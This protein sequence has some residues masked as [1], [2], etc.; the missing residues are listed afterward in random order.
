MDTHWFWNGQKSI[1]WFGV[2]DLRIEK[3]REKN[4][5]FFSSIKL[6][7]RI[8]IHSHAHWLHSYIHLRHNVDTDRIT[9]F[10][11][12]CRSY[13]FISMHIPMSPHTQLTSSRTEFSMLLLSR[14]RHR[15]SLVRLIVSL[16]LLLLFR[17][18]TKQTTDSREKSIELIPNLLELAPQKL[19]G[20]FFVFVYVS[21]SFKTENI[22]N[23]KRK[24]EINK[25]PAT[26]HSK[27]NKSQKKL[28]ISIN[29][30]IFI[31]YEE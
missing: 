2:S 14:C 16:L 23:T 25:R 1:A 27:K 30:S 9:W 12:I 3:Q 8:S 4:S 11:Y 29:K 26:I 20:S 24:N 7:T 19:D 15:Q 31:T 28:K 21:C 13:Y 18:T 5:I 6:N 22:W 10:Y 17:S